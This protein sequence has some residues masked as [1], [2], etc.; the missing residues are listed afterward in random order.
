MRISEKA[1]RRIIRSSL[2]EMALK[3]MQVGLPRPMAPGQETPMYMTPEE[4]AVSDMSVGQPNWT[5]QESH[6]AAMKTWGRK[7]YESYAKNQ[8][9]RLP[10]GLNVFVLPKTGAHRTYSR[11]TDP[12][13][14]GSNT[15]CMNIIR[16]HFPDAQIDPDDLNIVILTPHW[17]ELSNR[18]GP[19][20]S[21]ADFLQFDGIY[22]TVH[23][24]FDS[25]PLGDICDEIREDV[26]RVVYLIAGVPEGEFISNEK[27]NRVI[28]S[29]TKQPQSPLN[30]IFRLKTLRSGRLNDEAEI[31]PELCTVALIRN[32]IPV[33]IEA[34]PS[35]NIDGVEFTPEEFNE[36][37]S[38]LEDMA[39]KLESARDAWQRLQGKTI[40]GSPENLP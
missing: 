40:I 13:D 8:F 31:A 38:L 9:E 1:I 23:A 10:I 11:F 26:S 20:T 16:R 36:G 12:D 32:T 21:P 27:L 24:L 6:A 35:E 7:S 15:V 39:M 18:T 17:E 19:V 30:G 22:N 33:N 25:G 37:M 28:G 29:R 2:E 4:F 3:T 34:F 5:S 14:D